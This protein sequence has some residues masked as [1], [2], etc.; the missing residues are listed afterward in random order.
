VYLR[1]HSTAHAP[2]N[3]DMLRSCLRAVHSLAKL[4]NAAEVPRFKLFMGSV[5]L[6]PALKVR[7][8]GGHL[9]VAHAL[10]GDAQCRRRR[11]EGKA[12]QDP[13]HP[14]LHIP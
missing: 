9:R 6:S 14:L 1:L 3:E 5:V 8:E 10:G 4:P 2:G 13:R 7:G 11:A 12:G